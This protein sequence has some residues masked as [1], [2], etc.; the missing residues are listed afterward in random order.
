[1]DDLPVENG[2]F[3]WLDLELRSPYWCR[4]DVT[5]LRKSRLLL[6][7]FLCEREESGC[8]RIVDHL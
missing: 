1:M 3:P 5:R 7:E 8:L 6:A 4:A 2:D